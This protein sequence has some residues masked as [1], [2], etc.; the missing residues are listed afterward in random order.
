MSEKVE[1]PAAQLRVH[2]VGCPRSG[3]TLMTE[4][5][6]YAYDFA[7]AAGHERSL[8]DSIPQDESPY[9]TKKPADTIRIGKAFEGDDNLYVIALVRDPR[10]VITSVHWSHPD[11]YFVGFSRW[12]AYAEEIRRYTSHPRYLLVRY[13]DL[14]SDPDGQQQRITQMLPLLKKTRD[15][16]VY[17]EGIEELHEH[18]EKALGGVRPFDTSRVDAWREHL[19]R[20]R[21]EYEAHPAFQFELEA[22]DYE[23]DASWAECLNTA[24]PG[25]ESYKDS[26]DQWPGKWE[27]RLRY[28]LKTRKYLKALE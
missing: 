17:P 28:W 9:L 16:S 12:K 5:L 7:G 13:E 21:A 18:S 2:V 25:G 23:P 1:D 27:V 14:L 3:T 20:I 22:F 6:R 8:F 11:L 26:V 15:F 4:L 19:G 24:T 10:A